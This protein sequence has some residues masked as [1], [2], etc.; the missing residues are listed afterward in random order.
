[1]D[2][3]EVIFHVSPDHGNGT[4]ELLCVLSFV[5]GAVFIISRRWISCSRRAR[6]VAKTPS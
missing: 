6:E 1:M 2:F 3:I 4:L 5:L